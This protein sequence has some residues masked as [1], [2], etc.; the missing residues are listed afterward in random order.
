MQL[1]STENYLKKKGNHRSC[2]QNSGRGFYLQ[3]PGDRV[4]FHW[5]WT[6]A[7]VLYKEMTGSDE[8][9]KGHVIVRFLHD[10]KIKMRARQCNKKPKEAKIEDL[11]KW[12]Y[13]YHERCIRTGYGTDFDQKWGYFKPKQRLNVDQSPLPFVIDVKKTYEYIEPGDKYHNTWI[14]QP[15]SGLDKRQCSLQVM[16]RPEGKQPPPAIIFR[17]CGLR[18][19]QD[20]KMAWH[21]NVKVF[22][23]KNTWMDS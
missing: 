13:N 5:L 9:I 6:K 12:H 21:P 19:S 14:S 11:K 22:F 8:S 2:T 4:N 16:F 18:I 20:E 23:Q 1:T 3:D 15:G 7:R 17:G 10:Y